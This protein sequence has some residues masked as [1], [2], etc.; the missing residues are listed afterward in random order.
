MSER[1]ET[2]QQQ[3]GCAKTSDRRLK[4]M[5]ADSSPSAH[6]CGLAPLTSCRSTRGV[7]CVGYSRVLYLARRNECKTSRAGWSSVIRM[8]GGHST[9]KP[10]PSALLRSQ[11][12]ASTLRCDAR[13]GAQNICRAD[14]SSNP[15]RVFRSRGRMRCSRHENGSGR[16]A[17][18]LLGPPPIIRRP[19]RAVRAALRASP[20]RPTQV[21]SAAGP[22]GLALACQDHGDTV[23]QHV[24]PARSVV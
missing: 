12:A 17:V 3:R 23:C 24:L 11:S 15:A 1:A 9:R 13:A 19:S 5:P 7:A 21:D 10:D 20:W 4:L 6:Q 2:I 22:V 18:A 8:A 16:H 14:R